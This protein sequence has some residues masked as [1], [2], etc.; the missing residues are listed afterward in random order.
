MNRAFSVADGYRSKFE[1]YRK[2]YEENE[3]LVTQDMEEADHGWLID[4]FDL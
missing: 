1:P 2:F 3:M 4:G